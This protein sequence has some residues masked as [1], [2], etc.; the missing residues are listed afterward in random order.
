LSISLYEALSGRRPWDNGSSVGDIIIAVCTQDVPPLH[1]V[2][3]WVPAELAAVV[4]KG[5]QRDPSKR[6]ATMS[7]LA[8]ALEPFAVKSLRRAA[9]VGVPSAGRVA[10]GPLAAASGSSKTAYAATLS[11]STVEGAKRRPR[12]G[13]AVLGALSLVLASAGA[14]VWFK[15]DAEQRRARA[16]WSAPPAAVEEPRGAV[17]TSAEIVPAPP[18]TGVSSAVASATPAS[19]SASASATGT[20]SAR[21]AG[22]R[23]AGR[24]APA[25]TASA[26]RPPTPAGTS[27]F[28]KD[29]GDRGGN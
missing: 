1:D 13:L 27:E 19:A 15:H 6:H 28:V 24:P 25:V 16:R 3:P 12:K 26:A 4:H 20:A 22:A 8:A 17:P 2:A 18:T 23:P 14:V 21:R 10:K 9:L 7:E 29:R 5:L 11:A